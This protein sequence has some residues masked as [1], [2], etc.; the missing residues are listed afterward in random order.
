MRPWEFYLHV[1][2]IRVLF[3][4]CDVIV[5]PNPNELVFFLQTLD[6]LRVLTKLIVNLALQLTVVIPALVL[7][8]VLASA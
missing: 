7:A 6:Q 3:P 4:V 2:K 1:P 5:D 8:S